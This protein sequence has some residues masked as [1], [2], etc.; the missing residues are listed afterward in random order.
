M[1]CILYLAVNLAKTA[2]YTADSWLL[3]AISPKISPQWR[4]SVNRVETALFTPDS[5]LFFP[6]APQ[7]APRRRYY[8]S[9]LDDLRLSRRKSRRNGA[10]AEMGQKRDIARSAARPHGANRCAAIGSARALDRQMGHQLARHCAILF[11]RNP[12]NGRMWSQIGPKHGDSC[13]GANHR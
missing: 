7:N 6:I 4:D 1:I 2:R 9:N 8:S 3:L 11:R 13:L 12:P 10:I 5:G